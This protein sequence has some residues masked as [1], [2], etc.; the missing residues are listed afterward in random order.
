VLL[1]PA[2]DLKGGRCVRLEQGKADR[3]KVY[4]KDPAKVAKCWQNEGARYLHV[5]DLDGAFSGKPENL[6]ALKRILDAVSIPVEFGG[7][8]RDPGTISKLLFLGVA[9]VILGTAAIENKGLVQK[10]IQRFGPERIVVGIDAR[11]GKVAVRGWKKRTEVTALSLAKRMK[12]LGVQRI[13]YTDIARDGMLSGPNL[14]GLKKMARGSGL[15]VIASGGISSLKDIK[16][17]NA[18][19]VEG[20]I[21]GKALYE[22]KVSLK[23]A[24]SLFP[25]EVRVRVAAAVVAEGKL[26]LVKHVKKGRVWWCLPGG[27]L[28]PGETLEACAGRELLEETGL[29]IKAE[30]P[31]YIGELILPDEHILDIVFLAGK[32]RGRLHRGPDKCIKALRFVPLKDL[33]R[34]SFLPR[35]VANRFE[36]DWKA[37]FPEGIVHLGRYQE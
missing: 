25:S 9:R 31:I 28:E 29:R 15:K 30:R 23:A 34:M 17:V 4:S 1:I 27:G 33:R 36:E 6:L 21:I 32:T 18:L 11:G 22:A 2:I 19:S 14:P 8:V 10:A 3:A 7:G 12:A 5:V 24:L 37:G 20:L 16:K 35:E 26:L 13:I